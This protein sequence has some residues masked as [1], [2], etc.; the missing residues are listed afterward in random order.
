MC[1]IFFGA[2]SAPTACLRGRNG[3]SLQG[4]KVFAYAAYAHEI[5]RRLC[6][7]YLSSA[8][9]GPRPNED[10]KPTF[11]EIPTPHT[12]CIQLL[13]PGSRLKGT[14]SDKAA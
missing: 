9:W 1:A 2:L 6:R 3:R 11:Q 5:L 14:T 4:A 7:A 8:L 13:R 12:A 10:V